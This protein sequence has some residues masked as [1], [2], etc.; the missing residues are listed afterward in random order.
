VTMRETVPWAVE[1]PAATEAPASERPVPRW[2]RGFAWFGLFLSTGGCI[3]ILEWMFRIRFTGDALGG[4]PVAQAVW[5]LV[6]ALAALLLFVRLPRVVGALPALGT[7]WVILLL[8]LGSVLWS[9]APPV[10][11]RRSVALLGTSVFAFYLG[12]RYTRNEVFRLLFSVFTAVVLL[13]F[14]AAR[15]GIAQ[16]P[17]TWQGIFTTKNLLGQ[18]M[19]L[20]AIVSL[21]FALS[22]SAWKRVL[23]AAVFLLSCALLLLSDSKTALVVLL[24]A[25]ML[26]VPLRV[27]RLRYRVA[28][29]AIIALLVGAG[30]MS[31]WLAGSS[32]TVL[33]LLGRNASLT[34]RVPL[35][36]MLWDMIKRSPWVGYGYGGF[37]LYW[38]G[39]S[40]AIWK[41]CIVRWGWLPPNG[42]DGFI[43]LWLDLGLVGVLAF[44][45]S[46]VVSFVR[47]FRV[48]HDGRSFA[49]LFPIMFLYFM[50]LGNLT[51]SALVTHN[52][53]IW[54]LFVAVTTQ[55]WV[56]RHGRPRQ[57][58]V[59]AWTPTYGG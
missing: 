52:S 34:G 17:G 42:H 37:W 6:Y 54:V 13:S 51:E 31:V 23:G 40:A 32:D 8:A 10:T 5:S 18:A 57:P 26:M 46:F 41:V 24:A 33:N 11:L 16:A 27:I 43:D 4:D 28:E 21:L 47:A 55:L 44:L 35:W 14:L 39:P 29:L 56:T 1:S 59:G 48:A 12:T 49:D 38:D 19:E 36:E 20:S 25:L 58:G 15:L 7:I 53:M 2:E 30:A 9:A 50:V 22:E 45:V 3:P